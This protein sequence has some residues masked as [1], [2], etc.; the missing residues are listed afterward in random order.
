MQIFEVFL[1]QEK[2]QMKVEVR[3]CQE[4]LYVGNYDVG[5]HDVGNY[6][7][8]NYDVGYYD[9][10]N[11]DVGNYDVENCNVENYDVEIFY[12]GNYDG[13]NYDAKL[14]ELSVYLAVEKTKICLFHLQYFHL[15]LEPLAHHHNHCNLQNCHHNSMWNSHHLQQ[16]MTR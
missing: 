1:M 14:Y 10:G 9:V 4:N 13:V 12:V 16:T 15:I 5:N 7:V 3:T 11:Y 6:D 8:G 2:I